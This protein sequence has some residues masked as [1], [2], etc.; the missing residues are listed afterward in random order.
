M[1][2]EDDHVAASSAVAEDGI[3]YIGERNEMAAAAARTTNTPRVKS[4][5]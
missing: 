4:K 1:I 2:Y 5:K 3:G